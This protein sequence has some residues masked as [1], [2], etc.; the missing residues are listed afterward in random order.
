[1]GFIEVKKDLLTSVKIGTI[2]GE[3]DLQASSSLNEH[4]LDAPLSLP[5]DG[6]L[7]Y[8]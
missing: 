2:D 7:Q 5:F 3:V 8:R 1:M 4:I 6:G